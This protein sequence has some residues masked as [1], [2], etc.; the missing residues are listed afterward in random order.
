MK[1]RSLIIVLTVLIIVSVTIVLSALIYVGVGSNN[2]KDKMWDYLK[3]NNY[4]ETDIQSIKVKHSFI[5]IILSYDEWIIDVVYADEPTS[6]Y[7]Y[8]LKDGNIVESGVTGTT[9]KE[10][11]KH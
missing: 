7:Y 6:V 5:N 11:L 8:T 3:E 10:D 9:D 4:E 1:K 2:V